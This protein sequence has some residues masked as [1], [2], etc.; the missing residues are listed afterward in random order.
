M[1]STPASYL[2]AS[3]RLLQEDASFEKAV[4]GSKA[5][6]LL[7]DG[8][9]LC[10]NVDNNDSSNTDKGITVRLLAVGGDGH[11]L[12][13]VPNR[14][15][16][17]A[18]AFYNRTGINVE[19]IGLGDLDNLNKEIFA[20]VQAKVYD[21]YIFL[22][23]TTGSLVE[24]NGLADLTEFV[25]T[26]P[27]VQWTDIFPFNRDVQSVYDNVVRVLPCDGDVHSL[28]YRKD[29]F[30]EFDIAVPRTWDEYTEVAAF[31][32]G[33]PVPAGDGSNTTVTLSGSCVERK[34]TC[35]EPL[36]F[37]NLVHSTST[38]AA[39]GTSSGA[40]LDPVT[41]EPLMGEAMAETLRHLESQVKYGDAEGGYK[42][43]SSGYSSLQCKCRDLFRLTRLPFLYCIVTFK[44]QHTHRTRRRLMQWSQH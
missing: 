27:D 20:D 30:E 4:A 17:R 35:H 19:V 25:A 22:P 31:F 10:D 23:F 6:R 39:G 12:N 5:G 36:Y 41:F 40:L 1:T 33:M 28:F 21:G 9:C 11:Y 8:T 7:Q 3:P 38:Q 14:F 18:P 44:Q 13:F 32:H 15:A 37:N 24:R 2:R 43:I 42:C 34:R 29:L 16:S 26:N